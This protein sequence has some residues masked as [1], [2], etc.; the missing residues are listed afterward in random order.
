KAWQERVRDNP[1]DLVAI[2]RLAELQSELHDF[3]ASESAYRVLLARLPLR[4][5][6]TGLGESLINQ[7]RFPEAGKADRAALVLDDRFALA[8]VGVG[9]TRAAQS[10]LTSGEAALRRAIALQPR[11]A[12]AHNSLGRVLQ[13]RN[14]LSEA[15][16]EYQLAIEIQPDLAV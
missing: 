7:G 12:E 13:M 15:G 6:H 9:V 10:D 16:A 11:L 2:E 3:R 1:D 5:W 4:S 8:Y 14:K